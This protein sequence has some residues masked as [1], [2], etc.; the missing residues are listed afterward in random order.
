MREE[1]GKRGYS[2]FISQGRIKNEKNMLPGPQDSVYV[3]SYPMK[4]ILSGN[5]FPTFLKCKNIGL[6]K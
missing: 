2:C 5:G 3:L 6:T 1:V 4:G